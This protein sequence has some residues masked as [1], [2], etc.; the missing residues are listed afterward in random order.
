[1]ERGKGV[2][3]ALPVMTN[4][5]GSSSLRPREGMKSTCKHAAVHGHCENALL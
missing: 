3:K 5:E 4:N 1:M 2:L